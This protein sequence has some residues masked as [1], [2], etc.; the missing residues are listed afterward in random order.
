MT[1][2]TATLPNGIVWL[3]RNPGVGHR[4][5]AYFAALAA[6]IVFDHDQAVDDMAERAVNRFEG[7]LGAGDVVLEIDDAG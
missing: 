5:L 4:A 2:R 6:N 7:V 3:R 1:T